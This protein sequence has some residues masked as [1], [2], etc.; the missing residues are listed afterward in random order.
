MANLSILKHLSI[1]AR[2][3]NNGEAESRE[4]SERITIE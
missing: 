1:L 3:A 2:S 4:R